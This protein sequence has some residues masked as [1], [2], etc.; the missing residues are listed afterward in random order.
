MKKLQTN[1]KR[2]AVLAAALGTSVAANA[3]DYT[4]Q[5]TA[6]AGEANT[7]Q[8]AVITAVIALAVLSFGV[9]SLLSWLG[10]K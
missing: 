6:A 4:S 2:A 8:T 3:A 10:R 9:G 7:N 1:A 5:I